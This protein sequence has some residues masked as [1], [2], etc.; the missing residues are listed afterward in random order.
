MSDYEDLFKT[1][2]R[3]KEEQLGASVY[4]AS[5]G[6]PEQSAKVYDLAK[7]KGL[8]YDYV[9]RH[10]DSVNRPQ[11][12]ELPRKVR[13]F[14]SD[15]RKAEIAIDD[16][17]NL[18]WWETAAQEGKNL[19]SLIPS[20]GFSMSQGLYA[21]GAAALNAT[22]AFSL[23]MDKKLGFAPE[24]AE[25][26]FLMSSGKVLQDIAANQRG[27]A[28]D[29][30][31]TDSVIPDPVLGGVKSAALNIPLIAASAVTRNPSIGLF[32]MGSVSFGESYQRGKEKGLS[33]SDALMLGVNNAIAEVV[34][35]KIPLSKFVGDIAG[36]AG[37]WRTVANQMATEIPTEQLATVWQDAS[38]WAALNPDKTLGE[39]LAERPEAAANTLVS[40][41]VATG[42]QTSVIAGVDTLIHRQEQ[43]AIEDIATKAKESKVNSRSSD[44]FAQ[45]VQEV[46]EEYGS[47]ENIY[48]DAKEARQ[49]FQDLRQDA[50]YQLI[51]E[52]I[53]EAEAVNG[54]IVIPIGDFTS[55]F[56]IS[57]NYGPLKQHFRLTPESPTQTDL[58]SDQTQ[59][60][61]DLMKEANE[62]IEV[63]N[64]ADQI[65][66]E[67]QTQLLQTGRLDPESAKVSASI[68]PAYVASR[69]VR[70]GKSVDEIYD[71]M[72]LR[73]IGPEVGLASSQGVILDQAEND[74]LAPM[75]ES[76]AVGGESL[77]FDE[78]DVQAYESDYQSATSRSIRYVKRDAE[79]NI[80][81]ALQIHT[82]G[83]RSKKATISNVYVRTDSRRQKVAANLLKRARQDFNVQHSKDLTN[84]GRA[85]ARADGKFYQGRNGYTADE[86][87]FF[88]SQGLLTDEEAANLSDYGNQTESQPRAARTISGAAPREQWAEATAIQADGRP[89]HVWRGAA[90][91]LQADDFGNIGRATGHPS[92]QLGVWF[93]S[94]QADAATYGKP[95]QYQLDI[96]NP[97]VFTLADDMPVFD[98]PEGYAQLRQQ[99]QAEGFD[100]IVLD[101]SEVGG[102]Q[103]IVA[104]EPEQVIESGRD[105]FQSQ[106]DRT[107]YVT[108]N[109]NAE[110]IRHVDELGGLAAPSLAVVDSAKGAFDNF[111]DISLL[112]YPEITGSPKA[113]TF[114]AD[115]YTP[116]HP[117]ANYDVKEKQFRNF[118]ESITASLGEFNFLSLPSL[119]EMDERGPDEL[120]NSPAVKY[121]FLQEQGINVRKFK[122]DDVVKEVRA[123]AKKTGSPTGPEN[124]AFNFRKNPDVVKQ[125][126]RYYRNAREELLKAAPDLADKLPSDFEE[127]GSL[128]ENKLLDFAR[129]V[130]RFNREGDINTFKVRQEIDKKFRKPK[131][132]QDY[133]AWVTE[134][135]NG[136][137]AGKKIFKGFTN[138]GNRRYIEYNLDNIVKEMTRQLQAGENFNYGAGTVRSAYATELKSLRQMRE[139]KDKLVTSEQMDEIRDE[140]QTRLM[141]ALDALRPYYK[142]DGDGFGY[143]DDAASAIAEGRKGIREAFDADPQVDLI[144][145]D[146]V[147]YLKDLPTEYFETKIQRAVDLGEFTAAVVPTDTPKDV[148]EILERNGLRIKKYKKGDTEA[149]LKAVKS[150]DHLL[151]QSDQT[152]EPT[153]KA[154]QS[155]QPRGVIS[156]LPKEA[157]IQ[158]TSASDLTT[159]LH[160]SGHLFLEME[161]RLFNHPEANDEIR[162]DG[163]VILD[164]L[165]AE[166]FDNISTE[167]HEKFARGFESYLGEGKAPSVE[168]QTVFRRFAAW[169]KQVYRSLSRLNVELTDDMRN[170]FD[171]MLATDDQ[172]DRMKGRFRPLFESAEDAGV[173]ESE[174]RAY[175]RSATPEAAKE[176]LRAKLLK[177]LQRQHKQWWK[178]E[179]AVIAKGIREELLGEPVYA[180]LEYV[181]NTDFTKAEAKQ[182]QAEIEDLESELRRLHRTNPSIKQ[183]IARAGGINREEAAAQGID[184]EYFKERFVSKGNPLFPQAGGL[185]FD[186][187]AELLNQEG[188]DLDANGALE[189]IADALSDDRFLDR[190]IQAQADMIDDALAQ[191][192]GQL[193]EFGANRINRADVEAFYFGKVPGRFIGLTSKNGMAADNLA[194]MFGLASGWDLIE[195]IEKSS[196]LKQ[197]VDEKT[198]QEMVRRHGDAMTDG[199]LEQIAEQAAHNSEYG[200]KLSSEIAFLSRKTRRPA[201]DRQAVK[202]YAREKIAGMAY[203]KIYPNR[204]RANEIRSARAAAEAKVRGDIELALKH[205]QQELINFYL[206]KEAQ[207]A[208]DKSQKIR[209]SLKAIQTR[210]YDS[211]KIDTEMVNQAKVLIAAYDFRKSNRES[212][213]LAKARIASVKNWIVSQQQNPESVT[214]FVEAEVLGRLIPYD[215]MSYADL[216]GV[217]D[218]VKSIMFGAKKAVEADSEA[219][220]RE[221]AE[222]AEYLRKN[223]ID[224]YDAEIDSDTPWVRAKSTIQDLFASL[225]KMESLVRQADG[226]NEQGW[227]W[228]HTIKPLLDASNNAL[229]MRTEAH[230]ALNEMFEGFEGVFNGLKDRRT[231]T[232]DSGRKITMSYGARLSM[233]LNMGNDSNLDALLTMGQTTPESQPMMTQ[234]DIDRIV[235]TLSERDWDL[236]QEIWDY[237]D[238]YWPQIAELEIKR[239][240]VAPQKVPARGF[241][242]PTGKTMKGGYYPLV[243]DP[244]EDVKQMDQ[245]ISAQADLIKAGGTAKK[246]TKHGSTIERVGF[247]GKK[248][249]FSINVLFNHIDG[250]VHDITHWEAIRDVDRVLRNPK[251]YNEL[252]TSL[253]KPGARAI[254][255]RLTEVAAGPQKINGMRGWQRIL[256]HTRLA[257]TYGALGYSVRTALMNT[258][259]LTTAIA[260]M[261][262]R[263]VAAGTA[264]YYNNR[265]SSDEMILSKSKYMRDRGEVLTRDVATIRNSLMGNTKW[266]KFRDNAFWLMTQTDKAITRPIWIAAYRQGETM[267]ESEQEAIDYA[268]RMVARTQGSGLDMDLANVET[269]NELM[270]TMTVMFSAMSAIYNISTEQ[271]KRKKAG[272]I[273]AVELS[274]KFA[275]LL[276]VPAIVE[277]MITG[278]GDE[279]EPLAKEVAESVM[280][281][282]LGLFP[283]ARD[284][285]SYAKY[286]SSFPTPIVQLG[287]API[288]LTKQVSQGEADKGMLRASTDMLSWGLVPGTAQFNRT[289]GYLMDLNEGEIEEFSV[290]DMIVTGKESD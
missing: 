216:R 119:H 280:F 97:K 21:T 131:V 44:T 275:W 207:I 11:T 259:G 258:L 172:I 239:S 63:R 43:R 51:A 167:Q 59:S 101:Y 50:A 42:L 109:L 260:D 266:N 242:T 103:H 255:D 271:I 170:V 272:K 37:F 74:W 115:I 32:G 157:I 141:E 2:E 64:R 184:P 19:A 89:A 34:T 151:F 49:L 274:A 267:F 71:M 6:N 3:K 27:A 140:S 209:A 53:D 65:Y 290:Y 182:I 36:D 277:L 66:T 95:S 218:T 252:A 16:T 68:I 206:A 174:Y 145:S 110:N 82:K 13:E 269:R 126:E 188:Y 147:S 197:A 201:I 111:G 245:D 205:K 160:E 120:L 24:N 213:E 9:E 227:M 256:R 94:D 247:G 148:L 263:T 80:I 92:A 69:A 254:K 185:T 139:A 133:Q 88:K 116:R 288:D 128:K 276:V 198:H 85:F 223:R 87:E 177:Q 176:Q 286:G 149:R 7:K 158:L 250:V 212:V 113:R 108:H 84:D 67:I 60:I 180:A 146:L 129:K 153:A 132:Q 236:V 48:L 136:M 191:K 287:K 187:I 196:T 194:A 241:T 283:V 100:G 190:D 61:L 253:G 75:G 155:V 47:V 18:S 178:D 77:L 264:E 278:G 17:D 31:P 98:S 45:H 235:G 105:L 124:N 20:A 214:T 134:H 30:F 12:E 244:I 261:D 211:K 56:A 25:A 62:N 40:T 203:K 102:Q 107:L 138:A 262:A 238:S 168:L 15:R 279:D 35:E 156:L 130:E 114:D 237:I 257:A 171:R 96:R 192:M 162:R 220:K 232:L 289:V 86:L 58:K 54:D 39:F 79:G 117:R 163:Q 221:I 243:G 90:S 152:A 14:L 10:Y 217:D 46:A 230:R 285:A 112:A 219:Y 265:K 38:D 118:V 193:S 150:F 204:Y 72:G 41:I 199:T 22:G 55:K 251:I 5:Q 159:F 195:Q 137:L 78:G 179:S 99:L 135:F 165:G 181:R 233:A 57:E 224:T 215:E 104:F 169:I 229:A 226:M 154:K 142:F 208:K 144:V 248:I 166:S 225:R 33:E 93:T 268:D 143:M 81:G 270:K 202:E 164:W 122:A 76:Y 161:G 8:P 4:K 29:F 83:P 106:D 26:N 200:K 123:A 249:D 228:K 173:T 210:K 121:A 273:N 52:Q 183:A 23:W 1:V 240:G 175:Q 282:S 234:R 28:E 222:G 281:Y 125:A 284:V 127:D 246:T 70:S 73:I 189:M 186:G 231:F 91:P